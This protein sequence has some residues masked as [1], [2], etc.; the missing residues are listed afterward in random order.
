MTLVTDFLG[1]D[2]AVGDTIVY[3]IRHRSEMW[4]KKA[5]VSGIEPRGDNYSLVAYDPDAI[6]RRRLCIKNLHTVVVVRKGVE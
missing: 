5:I 2:I 4:L 1:K 3:P 6:P